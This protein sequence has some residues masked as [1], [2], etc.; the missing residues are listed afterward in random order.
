M[1]TTQKSDPRP[2]AKAEKMLAGIKTST[3][4]TRSKV[5][6]LADHLRDHGQMDGASRAQAIAGHFDA[7]EH[8]LGLIKPKADA[9][10]LGKCADCNREQRVVGRSNCDCGGKVIHNEAWLCRGCLD[11]DGKFRSVA[12]LDET[13]CWNCGLRPTLIKLTP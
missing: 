7:V 8:M 9:S 12:S 10:W 11:R 1:A 3:D 6:G 4:E 13:R 5:L 2:N